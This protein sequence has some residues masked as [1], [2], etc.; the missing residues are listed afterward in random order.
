MRRVYT[1]S[2]LEKDI[3]AMEPMV[4]ASV[5]ANILGTAL[6]IGLTLLA[7]AGG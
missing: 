3:V 6:V 2:F 7:L 1:K 5:V 4:L